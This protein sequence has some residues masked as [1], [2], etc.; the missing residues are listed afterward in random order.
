MDIDKYVAWLEYLAKKG[1]KGVVNYI[2]ARALGRIAAEITR[3]RERVAELEK[4][5]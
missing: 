2:D 5:K 4:M 1:G 3:L